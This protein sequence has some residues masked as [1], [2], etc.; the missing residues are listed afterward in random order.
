MKSVEE[1]KRQLLGQIKDL[2]PIWNPFNSDNVKSIMKDLRD[3]DKNKIS[4]ALLELLG[5]GYIIDKEERFELYITDKGKSFLEDSN[6]TFEPITYPLSKTICL[7]VQLDAIRKEESESSSESER[8]KLLMHNLSSSESKCKDITD[9][10]SE[11]LGDKCSSKEKYKNVNIYDFDN[12]N[13]EDGFTRVAVISHDATINDQ[14]Q[15][16][17]DANYTSPDIIINGTEINDATSKNFTGCYGCKIENVQ[18]Q[19]PYL[20]RKGAGEIMKSVLKDIAE[21]YKIKITE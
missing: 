15:A 20:E 3:Y 8:E 2:D 13:R 10:I 4:K 1:H 12:T 7:A 19:F 14:E 11:I 9:K 18:N 16:L 21:R 17:R 6:N 5:S